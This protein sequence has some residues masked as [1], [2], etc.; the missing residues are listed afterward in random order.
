M[1][2]ACK[3]PKPYIID[4]INVYHAFYFIIWNASINIGINEATTVV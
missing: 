4:K 3:I 1:E 2:S